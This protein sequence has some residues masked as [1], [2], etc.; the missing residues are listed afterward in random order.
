MRMLDDLK[1]TKLLDNER[2]AYESLLAEL[3]TLKTELKQ[4][5]IENNQLVM[6][7]GEIKKRLVK[8]IK[9]APCE[10]RNK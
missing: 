4:R 3:N 2:K 6:D 5:I 8:L 10:H 9:S 7:N 1:L